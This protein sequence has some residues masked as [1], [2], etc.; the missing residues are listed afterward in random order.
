MDF[1]AE[2]SCGTLLRVNDSGTFAE[3]LTN[4]QMLL[5]VMENLNVLT[6]RRI[7]CELLLLV[8]L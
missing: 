3:P 1:N 4:V 5:F 2:K 8:R 7:D 6:V